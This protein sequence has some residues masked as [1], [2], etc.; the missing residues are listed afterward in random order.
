MPRCQDLRRGTDDLERSA[1]RRRSRAGFKGAKDRGYQSARAFAHLEDPPGSLVIA[2]VR[3]L[4]SDVRRGDFVLFGR[5]VELEEHAA[6]GG[7]AR[8]E[9]AAGGGGARACIVGVVGE[10]GLCHLGVT[11][12]VGWVGCQMKCAERRDVICVVEDDCAR[13]PAPSRAR[14]TTWCFP[15]THFPGT[16]KHIY[17][18]ICLLGLSICPLRT[19]IFRM[20]SLGNLNSVG[21]RQ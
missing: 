10:L 14:L 2:V 8:L 4:G 7:R 20:I 13:E 9:A 11:H 6:V 5:H 17:F 16:S 18:C 19:P 15:L 1:E 21:G 3:Q 12:R